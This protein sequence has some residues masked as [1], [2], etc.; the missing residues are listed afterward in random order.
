LRLSRQPLMPKTR[1]TTTTTTPTIA[2][3]R[4]TMIA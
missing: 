4:R 2:I 1:S 3:V